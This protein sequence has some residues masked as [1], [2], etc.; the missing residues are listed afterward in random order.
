MLRAIGLEREEMENLGHGDPH[1][2]HRADGLSSRAG[3]LVLFD[4]GQEHGVH[5][6]LLKGI[7]Y[8][9]FTAS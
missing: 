2:L 3:I 1:V 6:I 9:F 4:L 8:R 7:A 5:E